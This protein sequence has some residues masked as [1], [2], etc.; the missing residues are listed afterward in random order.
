MSDT[1][2]LRSSSDEHLPD[3]ADYSYAYPSEYGFSRS[4]GRAK[5]RP[6]SRRLP[7]TPRA[8]P[9]SVRPLP[10]IPHYMTCKRCRSCV[11]TESSAL[12]ASAFPP[13]ARPFKGYAGKAALYTQMFN[14]R[15][16]QPVVQLMVTGAHT[17]QEV[18]CR[19]CSAY[20]GWY[21]VR[22]HEES[23]QWKEGCFLVELEHV[24]AKGPTSPP[25][26]SASSDDSSY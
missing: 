23:E 10:S 22:A 5:A 18:M 20:L 19:H 6:L 7:P 25:P 4:D 21:I 11:T 15:V 1:S 14:V 3:R 8:R 12:S 16:S 13:T 2:T 9:A 24:T 26:K 17:M